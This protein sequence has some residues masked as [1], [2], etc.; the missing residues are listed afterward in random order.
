MTAL[1]DEEHYRDIS[2]A[3]A[4]KPTLEYTDSWNSE[5]SDALFFANYSFAA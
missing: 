2:N 1:K 5:N 3:E 4:S